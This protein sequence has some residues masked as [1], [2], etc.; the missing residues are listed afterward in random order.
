MIKTESIEVWT[1]SGELAELSIGVWT[2]LGELSVGV[3]T[4]SG[5]L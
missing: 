3:Q 2:P 5:E 1:L 4:F